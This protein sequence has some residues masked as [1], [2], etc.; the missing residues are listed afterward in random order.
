MIITT[1]KDHQQHHKNYFNKHR[2]YKMSE[3]T[4]IKVYKINGVEFKLR[5]D[6][7][8][9]EL[10]EIEKLHDR[11]MT[12]DEITLKFTCDDIQKLFSIILEPVDP[13]ISIP[14][15]FDYAAASEEDTVEI[16]SAFFLMRL[17]T[18]AR[19]SKKLFESF[20]SYGR[21]LR[22]STEDQA[23]Q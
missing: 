18:R 21:S 7:N 1:S 5:H 8:N 15:G 9:R 11:V 23:K 22:K 10:E 12:G 16:Y 3:T 19:H 17:E 4:E 6:Y 2:G 14:E 13:S 20:E